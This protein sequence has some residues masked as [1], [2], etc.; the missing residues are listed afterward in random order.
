MFMHPVLDK[1][2]ELKWNKLRSSFLFIR[3][4]SKPAY[5]YS[6]KPF[7]RTYARIKWSWIVHVCMFACLHACMFACLHACMLACL[8]ACMFACLHVCMLACLHACM[9][10]CLHVCMLACLHVC[11][12][13]CLPACLLACLPDLAFIHAV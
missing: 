9:F 5:A 3:E 12:F 6:S 13:A 2:L 11:M 4:S 8:H 10:A 1:L 7:A